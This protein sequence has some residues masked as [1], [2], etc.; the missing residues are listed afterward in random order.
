MTWFPWSACIA[1]PAPGS[2]SDSNLRTPFAAPERTALTTV[3]TGV[4]GFT[5][6]VNA[7]V[8]A[9]SADVLSSE[10]STR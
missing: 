1:G 3:V 9:S 8:A 5:V 4:A 6:M 7:R 2:G 10:S